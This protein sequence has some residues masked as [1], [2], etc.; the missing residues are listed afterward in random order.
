MML[1]GQSHH[2]IDNKKCLYGIAH[3]VNGYIVSTVGEYYPN[4]FNRGM[5]VVSGLPI[6]AKYYE[7]M[8]FRVDEN[9]PDP[10]PCGLHQWDGAPLEVKFTGLD[11]K[12]AMTNHLELVDKYGGRN[13]ATS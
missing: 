4:G 11:P 3:E 8:V 10:M 1:C 7:T 5:E 12:Q 2:F 13:L 6:E 9:D